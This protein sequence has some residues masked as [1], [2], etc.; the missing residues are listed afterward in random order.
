MRLEMI[1]RRLALGVVGAGVVLYGPAVLGND[2]V[3]RIISNDVPHGGGPGGC[4]SYVV[5]FG[6]DSCGTG[7]LLKDCGTLQQYRQYCFKY[8]GGTWDPVTMRCI[9]GSIVGVDT[10][11]IVYWYTNWVACP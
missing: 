10:G 4:G 2:C 5:C 8:S 3:R 1:L 11:G 7:G 6:S 9:G